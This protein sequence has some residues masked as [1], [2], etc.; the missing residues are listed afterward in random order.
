MNRVW[1]A[2]TESAPELLKVLDDL[3]KDEKK[4]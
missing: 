1:L 2:A 4:E 3:L